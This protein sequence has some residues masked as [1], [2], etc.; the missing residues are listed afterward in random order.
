M[1]D[2]QVD[3]CGVALQC[4]GVRGELGLQRVDVGY[5]VTVGFHCGAVDHVHQH[6]APLDV[7][8]ELQAEAAALAM[9][10]ESGPGTSATVNVCSPADTTPRLGVSVVNG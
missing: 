10:P 1:A 7:P 9:R 4:R 2:R 3:Q 5:R 6:R 8:E